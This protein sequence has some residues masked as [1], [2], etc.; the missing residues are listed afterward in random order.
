M[1]KSL[2]SGLVLG[3]TLLLSMGAVS[4]APTVT[5]NSSVRFD[6]IA[7]N[8]APAVAEFYLKQSS[9]TTAGG[10]VFERSGT[11]DRMFLYM[12]SSLG[13]LN[14][15]LVFSHSFS[16]DVAA[17]DRTGLAFFDGLHVG[18]SSS[19]GANNLLVD[20]TSTVT[21][22]TILTPSSVQTV[23]AGTAVL[24]N[25]GS[26]EVA[27]NGGAITLTGTPTIA[28]GANGQLLYIMG[29][30]NANTVTFQDE[31]SLA[32]SNIE[33]GAASRDLGLGDVIVLQFRTT[34]SAWVEVSFANN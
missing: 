27:G 15:P 20:G 29:T 5:P 11:T 19:P 25:A 7:I 32:G 16:S 22:A 23:S 6:R 34:A 2:F 24:A 1:N 8:A 31:G 3:L 13:G 21:G 30:S 14:D 10:M 28:D 12:K 9:D 4:V 17:I 18:G 33:L 26:I